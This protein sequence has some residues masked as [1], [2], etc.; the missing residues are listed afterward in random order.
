V[1]APEIS[2]A[3]FLAGFTILGPGLEKVA[4][5]FTTERSKNTDNLY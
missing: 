3:G 1:G 4:W 5:Y 2:N